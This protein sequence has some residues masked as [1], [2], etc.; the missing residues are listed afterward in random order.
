M[1]RKRWTPKTELTPEL[2]KAREKKKWQIALRRYVLEHQPCAQYAPY[3]GLDIKTLRAWFEMQFEEEMN[4]SNFGETWQFEHIIPVVHFDFSNTADMKLCWNF[5][6]LRIESI[7]PGKNKS[8]RMD[9]LFSKSYFQDLYERT[10][11]T[12]C[13][14]LLEKVSRIEQS[15][16]VNPEKQGN[17]IVQNLPFLDAVSGYNEFEFNLLN[18][19]RT[20]DEVDREI[21]DLKKIKI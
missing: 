20:I 18:Q 4:W 3:F 16:K 19:G 15:E 11:Y 7:H 14:G 21:T 9:L 13:L 1:A 5:I 2:V 17:F 12:L 8:R 10:K 6:N